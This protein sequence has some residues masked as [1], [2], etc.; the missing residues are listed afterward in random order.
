MSS[1]AQRARWRAQARK[2]RA[3]RRGGYFV[4]WIPDCPRCGRCGRGTYTPD[5]GL[6]R[7]EHG[8]DQDGRRHECVRGNGAGFV[9]L[10][11][12]EPVR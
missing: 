5:G 10:V 3:R 7:I 12:G 2:R 6:L 1:I 9:Q 4:G 8:H 11:A